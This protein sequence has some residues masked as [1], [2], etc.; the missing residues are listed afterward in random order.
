MC[1]VNTAQLLRCFRFG[2]L[3]CLWLCFP[4]N[5]FDMSLA[6]S[7]S[8]LK[9]WLV[10]N[11]RVWLIDGSS[12]FLTISGS[13]S[14]PVLSLWLF[15]S[16]FS[17]LFSSIISIFKCSSKVSLMVCESL[18]SSIFSYISLTI[19]SVNGL[20]GSAAP[21][22]NI[23]FTDLRRLAWSGAQYWNNSVFEQRFTQHSHTMPTSISLFT[24]RRLLASSLPRNIDDA[25]DVLR[26]SVKIKQSN[27]ESSNSS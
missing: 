19:S 11:D 12:V 6:V 24:L 8:L 17:R 2:F 3:W 21:P 23:D 1:W 22:V 14:E 15:A 5:D 26:F 7:G 27:H 20:T 9:L 18:F 16:M 4:D 10:T 25:F 13:E